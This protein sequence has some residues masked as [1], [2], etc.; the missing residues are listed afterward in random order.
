MLEINAYALE[1]LRSRSSVSFSR[2]RCN[3]CSL[4]RDRFRIDRPGKWIDYSS[5]R[6]LFESADSVNVAPRTRLERNLT[7]ILLQRPGMRDEY[8]VRALPRFAK[9]D[10]INSSQRD[11]SKYLCYYSYRSTRRV[12]RPP[13]RTRYRKRSELFASYA[14]DDVPRVMKKR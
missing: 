6:R 2:F 10:L 5:Y 1:S 12:K 11:R 13:A 4:R 9:F 3:I 7:S 14:S 8:V